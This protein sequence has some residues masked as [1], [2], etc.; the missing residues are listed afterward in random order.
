[1]QSNL[2]FNLQATILDYYKT[3]TSPAPFD[4]ETDWA[5]SLGPNLSGTNGGAYDYRLF[6]SINYSRNDWNVLCVGAICRPRVSAAY[7]TQQAQGQQRCGGCGWA[8]HHAEL[9]ADDGFESDEYNLFDLSFGGTST[10]RCRSAAVSRTCSI[11]TPEMVGGTTGYPV[12]TDWRTSAER[13]GFGTPRVALRPPSR[14]AARTP[15]PGLPGHMATTPA[16]TTRSAVAP[17][18]A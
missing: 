4:V 15:S 1:M 14:R 3:K 7:A 6:G 9:H 16:T 17:S 13:L 18:S 10:T 2:G 5:G 11:P 12:G 8:R